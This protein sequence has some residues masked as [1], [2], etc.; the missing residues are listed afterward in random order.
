MIAAALS[1]DAKSAAGQEGTST[2][3]TLK[4]GT[5]KKAK[6]KQVELTRSN[7]FLGNLTEVNIPS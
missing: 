7:A 6:N 3:L 5:G 2:V 4:I 1:D